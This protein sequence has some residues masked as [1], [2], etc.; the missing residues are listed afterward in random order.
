M[1]SFESNIL[2]GFVLSLF[3]S[4]SESVSRLVSRKLTNS[5]EYFFLVSDEPILLISSLKSFIFNA[6][7][8]SKRQPMT[9]NSILIN[10]S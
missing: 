8:I 6:P 5:L 9:F 10:S 4:V 7:T 1:G 3:F 2:S